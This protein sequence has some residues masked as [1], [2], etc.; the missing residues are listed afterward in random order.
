MK[1]KLYIDVFFLL[2]FFMDTL[3]LFLIRKVLNCT[4]THVRVLSGG[5]F[6]AVMACVVTVIPS[7]PVW[8]RL[9]AGYG[10]VSICMIRIS[11][12]GMNFRMVLRAA[13][14][15]YG[16][17]F[18]F[19]GILLIL[20]VQIPIFRKSGMGLP[21]VC[22]TGM[23]TYVLV[24]GFH[25]RRQRRKRGCILPVKIVWDGREAVVQALVDTGNSLYE[26]ISHKPVSII[27]KQ[28]MEA[29][30]AGGCPACFRAIPFH[31]LGK[32]H[33]IL[34]GY[35]LTELIIFGENEKIKIERPMVG[36]FDGN[37]SAGAAY[38]MILHPTLTERQE[39]HL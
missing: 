4:A 6:G 29:V 14:Y 9:L 33:G 8:I 28:A 18:L 35:E 3:L 31:S 5:V 16:F 13:I 26:P 10:L 39:E 34:N 17:A 25:Q 1:Y 27:E 15:L 36:L 23:I 37:L 12:S 11:F 19:G 21:A 22:I 2:N 30:F 32:A 7:V 24:A 20:S 38:Q